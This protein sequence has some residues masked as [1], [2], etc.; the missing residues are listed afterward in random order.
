MI[1]KN[2]KFFRGDIPC[3]Y[4][5]QQGVKCEKCSY[6]KPVKQ[7]ILII[8]LGS[9]G[10]VIRTTPLLRKLKEKFPESEISW[11]SR[12]PEVIP[13]MVD[14]NYSLENNEHLMILLGEEFDF[15]FNLDKEKIACSLAKIICAKTKKGFTLERGK[16]VPI[17]KDA[18]RSWLL[19]I[20]NK[21]KKKNRKTYQEEIFEICGFKYKGEEYVI[22]LP[23][24]QP[25]KSKKIIIGLN[26]GC[27]QRWRTKAWPK[28]YWIRLAQQLKKN[29]E[30]WLL[31]G[32]NEDKLNKEISKISGA[33]YFGHFPLKKFIE[34]CN[35]VDILITTDT[36]ALHI[37]IGLKKKIV[38]LF[39]PTSAD[40][41]DL[42]GRGIKLHSNLSCLKCY[43]KTCNLHPNCMEKIPPENVIIAVKNLLNKQPC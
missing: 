39:G 26:T 13:S 38:A 43:K 33:K 16:C 42:Y 11:I 1:K 28:K 27:G 34:I 9:A 41:I 15:L 12:F 31:G 30:V 19:G 29:Y 23:K 35:A 32:K 7:R 36:L 40:E 37:G 14:N 2:C 5:T 17:D 10:D 8:K 20:D 3:L 18:E 21:L 25:K 4:H 6:Y 24:T 22:D